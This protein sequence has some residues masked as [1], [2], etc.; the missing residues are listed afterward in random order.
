MLLHSVDDTGY[1][2]EYASVLGISGQFD[3]QSDQWLKVFKTNIDSSLGAMADSIKFK[4]KMTAPY[5]SGNLSDS[6]RV[7]G[8]NL[9]REIIFGGNGIMYGA[10]QERGERID[11]SHKVKNY[12]TPG[13]DK[14][15]LKNALETA[16]KEGIGR[17]YK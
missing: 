2:I 13:T 17:F 1:N 16:L 5:K 9:K 8:K 12:T 10:Y 14:H 3:K 7:E 6:G 15:Y 4:A 11:G